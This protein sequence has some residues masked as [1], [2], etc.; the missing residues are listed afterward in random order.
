MT[1]NNL[2]KSQTCFDYVRYVFNIFL[3]SNHPFTLHI[4]ISIPHFSKV[5]D[6][7]V[8][9]NDTFQIAIDK[10]LDLQ[11]IQDHSNWT[12]FSFGRDLIALDPTEQCKTLV[13]SQIESLI[14][15]QN[16]TFKQI[17]VFC[18]GKL[19]KIPYNPSQPISSIMELLLRIFNLPQEDYIY[20]FMNKVYCG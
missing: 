8:D 19:T 13:F 7:D 15:Q 14:L 20:F 12:L 2:Q 5:V 18:D 10:I 4:F 11:N 1:T 16:S 17:S 9:L 3:M 6:I